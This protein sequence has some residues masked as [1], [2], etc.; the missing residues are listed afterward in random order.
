MAVRRFLDERE[1]LLLGYA[2]RNDHAPAG[3]QLRE[4]RCRN[5]IACGRDDDLV[6]RRVFRPSVITVADPYLDLVV[7]EALQ[8]ALRPDRELTDDVDRIYA[9]HELREYGGLI[10]GAGADLE[11]DI[12]RP[13]VEHVGHERNDVRLRYGFFE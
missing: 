9:L 1:S 6:V 5:Q 3:L 10:T 13:Q 11:N 2:G 4:Q 12:A 8:T 7:S